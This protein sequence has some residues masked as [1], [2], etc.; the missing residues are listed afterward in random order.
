MH[1]PKRCEYNNQDEENSPNIP[2]DSTKKIEQENK[3]KNIE[4]ERKKERRKE[5]NEKKNK[6]ESTRK[7]RKAR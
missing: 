5:K 1:R 3:R 6:K 4:K 2:N 7:K